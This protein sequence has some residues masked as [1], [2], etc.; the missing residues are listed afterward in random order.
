ME[1][2]GHEIMVKWELDLILWTPY[3]LL[4]ASRKYIQTIVFGPSHIDIALGTMLSIYLIILFLLSLHIEK[5]KDL[6][7]VSE[8]EIILELGVKG[9]NKTFLMNFWQ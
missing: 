7:K 8:R 2:W 1:E 3:L 4:I 6:S 5:P 9:F